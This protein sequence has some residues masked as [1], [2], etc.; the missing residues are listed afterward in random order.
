MTVYK[1][2]G[3]A[4]PP[5]MMLVT[6]DDTC[7]PS[8]C[9]STMK[10]L[11]TT[12]SGYNTVVASEFQD[13]PVVIVAIHG[14]NSCSGDPTLV[15]V[16]IADE[17]CLIS[18]AGKSQTYKVNADRSVTSIAY[19]TSET[20]TGTSETT[21]LSASQTGG[22]CNYGVKMIAKLNANESGAQGAARVSFVGLVAAVLL[23]VSM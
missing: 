18:E 15:T 20:C 13:K 2:A 8:A 14:D 10:T 22:Q 3:C 9:S 5:S 23:A 19:D 6:P 12:M 17:T 21:T 1:N 11:C 16:S 7:E 4:A